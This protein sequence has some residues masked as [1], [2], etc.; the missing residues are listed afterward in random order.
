MHILSAK[1]ARRTPDRTAN[2][3]RFP[4]G[5]DDLAFTATFAPAAVSNWVLVGRAAVMLLGWTAL[6]LACGILMELLSPR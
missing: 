5:R 2:I 4:A 6:G 3:R 1:S